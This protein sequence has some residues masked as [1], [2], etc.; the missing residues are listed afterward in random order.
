MIQLFGDI[1][2]VGR[3]IEGIAA[4]A[5]FMDMV[6]LGCQPRI[7][8]SLVVGTK[9]DRLGIEFRNVRKAVAVA[10][11]GV[12]VADHPEEIDARLV[13]GRC[14]ADRHPRCSPCP[15]HYAGLAVPRA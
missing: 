1:G 15:P 10:V 13:I 3:Q 7:G 4:A 12:T 11:V 8:R 9:S 5:E 14:A 2:H 6:I